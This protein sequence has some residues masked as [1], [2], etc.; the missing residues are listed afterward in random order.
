MAH[1]AAAGVLPADR[2]GQPVAPAPAV[3]RA[4]C[5]GRPRRGRRSGAAPRVDAADEA[6]AGAASSVGCRGGIAPDRVSRRRP[7][8]RFAHDEFR[9]ALT[10]C[11]Y[12]DGETV[13]VHYRWG[14]G[15]YSR[16]PVLLRKLP[17]IPVEVIVASA[18]V[19]LAAATQA[20]A[21]VPIVMVELGDP[22]G[23]GFV[24]RSCR[25]RR[26]SRSWYQR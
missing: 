11:G 4:E 12:L 3:V 5:D 25:K 21:T 8:L 10:A 19:A 18:T 24:R 15:D 13:R 1:P 17:D 2:S 22:V 7:A 23:Y 14:E 26:G 9:R 20:T 6:P 16:C